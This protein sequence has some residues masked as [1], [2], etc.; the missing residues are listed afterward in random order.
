VQFVVAALLIGSQLESNVTGCPPVHVMVVVPSLLFVPVATVCPD[1]FLIVRLE[2]VPMTGATSSRVKQVV[3]PF[4]TVTTATPVVMS[5]DMS[6][7][8]PFE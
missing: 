4:L 8:T 6:S 5:K 2:L 7:F 1:P 3:F